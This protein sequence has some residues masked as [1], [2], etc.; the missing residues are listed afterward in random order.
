VRWTL[1]GD[2]GGNVEDAVLAAALLPSMAA[3]E[4]LT[5]DAPV[6]ARLLSSIPTIQAVFE[7]WSRDK[8]LNRGWPPVFRRVLVHA[9]ERQPAPAPGT[10]VGAFFTGGVDS[11]YT[12]LKRRE[13]LTGLVF[14]HGFDVPLA[15]AGRREH[16]SN[17]V[18]AA[19][20]ELGLPLLEVETDIRSFSDQ[21][22]KWLD[23]HGAALASVALLLAP[24]F[25]RVYV[26]ATMTYA[27]LDPLGSH[28]LVDPLWST[29][30]VE[31]VH[32]GCEAT[33]LDKLRVIAGCE[34]ARDWLR[35]CPK[36]WGGTY[37]C[38]HCEKCL[39]TMVALRLLDLSGDFSSLP[40]LDEQA[41]RRVARANV[42][43][44]GATWK[45]YLHA[46]NKA[47]GDRALA[48]ALRRALRRRRARDL[49]V[50]TVRT[51]KASVPRG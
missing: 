39:R 18:R 21:S 28:P 20:A 51:L 10:G 45:V 47:G 43:G 23:Y 8:E 30:D 27:T 36:N 44:N 13:E 46:A 15:D 9:T 17:G 49:G 41:L 14:V 6:S 40:T 33:R 4:E 7:T 2:P 34:A 35:V 11:F 19:A 1:P 42:P 3:G 29:E 31:L 38:G 22:V 26:P 5:I 24:W 37:N 32:D 25:R 12:A 16:V 48:R 50:S